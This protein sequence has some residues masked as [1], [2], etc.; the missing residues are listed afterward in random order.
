[1]REYAKPGGVLE[2]LSTSDGSTLYLASFLND[3]DKNFVTAFEE[4]HLA[5]WWN[6]GEWWLLLV[7]L[8][9][10][11]LFALGYALIWVAKGFAR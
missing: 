1:M 11:L 3:A 7:S 9:P 4:Q 10:L 5:R 2:S 8:P 6:A